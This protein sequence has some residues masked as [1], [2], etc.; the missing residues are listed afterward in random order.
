[1]SDNEQLQKTNNGLLYKAETVLRHSNRLS[2]IREKKARQKIESMKIQQRNRKAP[3][4]EIKRPEDFVREYREK[5][6]NFADY[7][8]RKGRQGKDKDTPSVGDVVMLLRIRSGKNLSAQQ[9]RLL[10]KL[11]LKKQHEGT[12]LRVDEALLKLLQSLENC[13]VYGS[14]KRDTIRELLNKRGYLRKDKQIK[15]INSNQVVEDALGQL[16]LVCV[17]DIVSAV[18][19]GSKNFDTVQKHLW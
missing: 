18:F 9:T 19:R 5:Q 13:L 15:Q 8:K 2:E 4:S 11:R 16:G 12:I 1:M 6:K 7:K 10:T 17:D 3:K 14:L